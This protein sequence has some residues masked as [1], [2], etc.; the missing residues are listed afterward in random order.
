M[1]L[2][3]RVTN[4][5]NQECALRST[6][7]TPMSFASDISREPD[8]INNRLFIVLFSQQRAKAKLVAFLLTS[9]QFYVC[10]YGTLEGGWKILK[11]QRNCI[12]FRHK[13]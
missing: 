10:A 9:F 4:A 8:H 7:D 1:I 11:M 2:K 12:Q 13:S 3:Q 5:S 6:W